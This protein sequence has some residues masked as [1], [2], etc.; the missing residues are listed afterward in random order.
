MDQLRA[1]FKQDVIR[2]IM[3]D[4][5]ILIG[6]QQKL[7]DGISMADMWGWNFI[8][9]YRTK[10]GK[11]VLCKDNGDMMTQAEYLEVKP[12]DQVANGGLG[13]YYGDLPLNYHFYEGGVGAKHAGEDLNFF[14]DNPQLKIRALDLDLIHVKAIPLGLSGQVSMSAPIPDQINQARELQLARKEAA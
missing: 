1:T 3:I 8:S 10:D 12:W 9:P 13:F 6:D 14:S 7:I 11:V 2:A 5:D 4:D